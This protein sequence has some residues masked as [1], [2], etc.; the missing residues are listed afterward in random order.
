MFIRQFLQKFLKEN[1]KKVLQKQKNSITL[2]TH[3]FRKGSEN[4]NMECVER[5]FTRGIKENVH[6]IVINELWRYWDKVKNVYGTPDDCMSLIKLSS[7]KINE[8]IQH[9][10]FVKENQLFQIKTLTDSDCEVVIACMNDEELI[11]MKEEAE[12]VFNVVF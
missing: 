6:G 4:M 7:D 11:M 1:D 9:V 12:A 8:G 2:V 5:S 10:H 3:N